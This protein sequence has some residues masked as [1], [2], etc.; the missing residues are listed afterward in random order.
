MLTLV[1][2]CKTEQKQTIVIDFDKRFDFFNIQG[3]P[4]LRF[5]RSVPT[6][7]RN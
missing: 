6:T 2:H 4:N 7:I 5:L 1:R 3:V